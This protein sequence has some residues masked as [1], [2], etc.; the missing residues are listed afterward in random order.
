MR[1]EGVS[2]DGGVIDP[3][4]KSTAEFA[5]SKGRQQC[6][7]RVERSSVRGRDHLGPAG[8]YAAWRR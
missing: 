7:A 3:Q 8:D 2:V 5:E 1:G 4:V 6:G